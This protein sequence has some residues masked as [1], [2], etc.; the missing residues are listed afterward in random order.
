LLSNLGT[1]RLVI[2]LL[3]GPIAA[4]SAWLCAAVGKYGVHLDPSGVNALAVAGATAGVSIILKL[5]HDAEGSAVTRLAKLAS[6]AADKN[7]PSAPVAKPDAGSAT[8]AW[9]PDPAPAPSAP[10]VSS[11]TTTTV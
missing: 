4:A 3:G 2:G 8:E 10:I 7:S 11:T 5:I 1:R 9:P 6:D